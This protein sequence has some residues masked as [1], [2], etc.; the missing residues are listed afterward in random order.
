MALPPHPLGSWSPIQPFTVAVCSGWEYKK[1]GNLAVPANTSWGVVGLTKG[2]V[3]MRVANLPELKSGIKAF[4]AG[5]RPM[6]CPRKL[7][8]KGA[9]ASFF[10]PTLGLDL[11]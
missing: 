9:K 6:V 2:P 3:L 10:N 8:D 5:F 1:G 4:K 11:M 7:P